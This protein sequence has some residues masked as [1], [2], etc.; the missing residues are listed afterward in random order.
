VRFF[1][2]AILLGALYGCSGGGFIP[3][4]P[5]AL[6]GSTLESLVRSEASAS[7]LSPRLVRAMIAAESGGDPSAVSRAGAQ[8]LMQLMPGTASA[9]G[10]TDAFDPAQNVRGGCRYMRDLLERYHFDVSLALAA[11]NAG[12]GTVDRAQRVP[13]ISETKAYVAKITAALRSPDN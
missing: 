5:H 10:V 11:Y 7:G 13:D 12:P 4:G 8:G 2:A 6:D 3:N 9:Y 1:V